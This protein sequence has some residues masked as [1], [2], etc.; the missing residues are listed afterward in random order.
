MTNIILPIKQ[1]D[2]FTYKSK[3]GGITKGEIKE[4]FSSLSYD[5]D[6]GVV[7]KILKVKSTHGIEYRLDEITIIQ[8]FLTPEEIESK[9]QF[10]KKLQDLKLRS[11]EQALKH[12]RNLKEKGE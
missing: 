5:L 3:Y 7:K 6:E 8:K 10:F 12:F 1:G 2:F 9:R 11:N 4:F